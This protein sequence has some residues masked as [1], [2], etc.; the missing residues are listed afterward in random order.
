MREELKQATDIL[1]SKLSGFP[2]HGARDGVAIYNVRFNG[3]QLGALLDATTPKPSG[4]EGGVLEDARF[5]LAQWDGRGG[6]DVMEQARDLAAG[7]RGLLAALA[8]GEKPAP[9]VEPVAV[10]GF[11]DERPAGWSYTINDGTGDSRSSVLNDGFPCPSK[12]PPTKHHGMQ[13]SNVKPFFYAIPTPPTAVS[14]EDVARMVD[15]LQAG[16]DATADAMI[17]CLHT[18]PKRVAAAKADLY[19]W[20]ERVRLEIANF[21]GMPS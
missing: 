18:D 5:A 19:A 11:E 6:K 8:E 9:G 20:R 13:V 3:A 21:M 2:D 14:R 4:T 15:T 10:R 16:L 1:K 12:K 17:L 7:L